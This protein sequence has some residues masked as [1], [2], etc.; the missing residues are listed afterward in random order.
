MV[1]S[2]D[3]LANVKTLFGLCLSIH[4]VEIAGIKIC[5]LRIIHPGDFVVL[6]RSLRAF[7][8]PGIKIG[9]DR[10]HLLI[11]LSM[12]FSCAIEDVFVDAE[13]DFVDSGVDLIKLY[14]VN[15][16]LDIGPVTLGWVSRFPVSERPKLAASAWKLKLY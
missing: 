9:S 8:H 3:Q 13:H 7:L 16:R 15:E 14:N 6:L 12:I 5:A 4:P 10:S 1:L 2:A 11:E